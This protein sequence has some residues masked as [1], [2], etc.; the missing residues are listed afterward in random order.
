MSKLPTGT[1]TFLFTDIEGSTQLWENH[2][3]GMSIALARHDAILRQAIETHNGYVFK[4]AGDAFYAVF[5]TASAA[6]VPGRGSRR[7]DPADADHLRSR[8]RCAAGADRVRGYW[9]EGRRWLEE[10]LS[11]SRAMSA[12][13]RARGFNGI[14]V[15]AWRQGDYVD[16]ASA[17]EESL[18]L[19][20]QTGDKR[21]IACV[22]NILGLG[23]HLE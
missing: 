13:K 2:A 10:V 19:Y 8:A 22:L 5:D 3:D 18:A 21:G 16:A 9:S 11:A 14:G 1:I 23:E 17:L 15:L 4:T 12:A 20:R 6:P 7:P